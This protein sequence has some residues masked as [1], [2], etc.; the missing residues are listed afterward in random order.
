MD[1]PSHHTCTIPELCNCESIRGWPAKSAGP[2]FVQ[3]NPWIAQIH[4]LHPTTISCCCVVPRCNKCDTAAFTYSFPPLGM[5]LERFMLL[6]IFNASDYNT[7]Y[8]VHACM[9]F[10]YR[11]TG[12]LLVYNFLRLYIF[13]GRHDIIR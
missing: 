2:H 7:M 3:G 11:T 6:C 9:L 5:H 12:I 8:V 4:A 1:P 10:M 13:N